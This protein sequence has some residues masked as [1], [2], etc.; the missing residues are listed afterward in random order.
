[1]AYLDHL[2]KGRLL[3]GSP[4]TVAR[5]L[6]N[7]H[8][9]SGGFGVLLAMSLDHA[10]DREG[11]ERTMRLLVDEVLPRVADLSCE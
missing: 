10:D 5:K 9:M 7:L 1:M 3:V 11:W 2:A 4:D 8:E 6:R